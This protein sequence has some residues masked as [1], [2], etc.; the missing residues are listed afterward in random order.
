MK[1]GEIHMGP[2]AHIYALH[3]RAKIRS[4]VILRKIWE[5]I[6]KTKILP[7]FAKNLLYKAMCDNIFC[8]FY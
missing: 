5:K 1:L 4:L 8:A 6:C 3:L 7:D 2:L